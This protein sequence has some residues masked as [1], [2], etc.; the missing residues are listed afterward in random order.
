MGE[1]S[2][3]MGGGDVFWFNRGTAIDALAAVYRYF[4]GV[5]GPSRNVPFGVNSGNEWS[6]S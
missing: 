1:D 5:I 2:D 6:G 4:H 3:M